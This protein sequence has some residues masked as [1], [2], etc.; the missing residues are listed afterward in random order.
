[1]E[2]FGPFLGF[3]YEGFEKEVVELF[4]LIKRRRVLGG[5][6]LETNS[7]ISK[8]LMSKEVGE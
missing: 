3:S 4:M 6:G 5:R 8:K 1:M 2:E 7:L